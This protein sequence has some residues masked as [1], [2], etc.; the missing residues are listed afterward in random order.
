MEEF[1]L[2]A[3]Q[4]K[5]LGSRAA[6]LLR[7]E[8]KLPLNIYGHKEDNINLQ[9]NYR[10]FEKFFRAGH[11]ILAVQVGGKKEHGVVREVQYNTYGSE[12]LHVDLA[13]VDLKES[14]VMNVP[15]ETIGV[16]KGQS[17][18]GT[19]DFNLK[20]VHVEGPAMSIPEKIEIQIAALE[21]GE[22]V[23]V[24]DLTLPADCKFVHEEDE[25]VLAIHAQKGL[26]ES[27][28]EGEG[29]GSSEM[30]EVISKKK[31]DE[32]AGGES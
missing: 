14:I 12:I 20:D 16:A 17:S 15:V 1:V 23:R 8:G 13:R 32:E 19:L 25:I 24:R 22:D 10:E 9:V 29:E 2:E 27:A 28:D 6:A 3:E 18:G 21:V 7:G 31:E 11:R 4:R 30:P 26:D 5:D